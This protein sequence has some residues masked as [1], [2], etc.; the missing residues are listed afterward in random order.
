MNP[1]VSNTLDLSVPPGPLNVDGYCL[2]FVLSVFMF[3]IFQRSAVCYRNLVK[4]S[5]KSTER[6]QVAMKM[7]KYICLLLTGVFFSS[8][9]QQSEGPLLG[10]LNVILFLGFVYS[11]FENLGYKHLFS[12]SKRNGY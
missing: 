1:T 5:N 7:V 2:L 3:W 11:W 12:V 10:S 4:H 9:C 6:E 8:L